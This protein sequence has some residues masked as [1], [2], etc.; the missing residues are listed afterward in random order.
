[1]RH[2]LDRIQTIESARLCEEFYVESLLEEAQEQGLFSSS[3][4][5]RVQYECLC[6]LAGHAK[7]FHSGESSS[8][9]IED[10]QCI[11]GSI[12]FTIGVWLK[13]YPAPDDA[14]NA[15]KTEKME[16][17]YRKGRGRIDGMLAGAKANHEQLV[18]ELM[19]SENVYY[20]STLD[21]GISGFFKLY[22]PEFGAQ[23]IHITADY[24]LYNPAPK[25][26]GIEFISAYLKAAACENQFCRYFAPEDVQHLLCGYAKDYRELPF[27]I[28]EV[29]L[30]AAL[31]CCMAGTDIR[32]LNISESG[33][34]RLINKFT[35]MAFGDILETLQRVAG[36]LN[37]QFAFSQELFLYVED[38]LPL[39][40]GNIRASAQRKMLDRVFSLPDL[41]DHKSKVVFSFGKKMPDKNYR[42]VIEEIGQCRFSQDKINIVRERVHTLADLE[43]VLLDAEWTQ[44]ERKAILGGLH[45]TEIAALLKKYPPGEFDSTVL[46]EQALTSCLNQYVAGLPA[47]KQ[48]AVQNMC[49]N[50][51]IEL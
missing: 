16:D 36:A 32:R 18:Q 42:S 37:R 35:P 6:L 5:E 49:Q 26:A 31:G 50:M 14:V 7:R 29:V 9:R 39:I 15:L 13:T 21:D 23:E 40:A 43:D 47:N 48:A 45:L 8:I 46:R 4:K 24:P 22:D 44:G 12:L 28:Y 38:S 11:M 51:T 25:R 27:N 3:D 2:E 19:V 17:I 30:T 10:A 20:R 41:S 33:Q 1:M 34:T